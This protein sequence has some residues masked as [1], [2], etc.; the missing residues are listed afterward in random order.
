MSYDFRYTDE[1]VCDF[2]L[3]KSVAIHLQNDTDKFNLMV[4]MTR[5]LFSF[6]Q[7]KC[8]LEGMDPV[9]MQEIT[10]SGHLYLQLLKDRLTSWLSTL[11]MIILKR[12]RLVKTF[13]F[14]QSRLLLSIFLLK[15]NS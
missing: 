6:A 5:K 8:A 12:Q 7:G 2:F 3:K 10:L 1:Q 4:F 11:K 13:S 14:D 9:M 15:R